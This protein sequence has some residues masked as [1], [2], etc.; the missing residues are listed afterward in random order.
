MAEFIDQNL[1]RR[2]LRKPDWYLKLTADFDRLGRL[3]E[4]ART[5]NPGQA[6][7]VKAEAYG[8]VERALTEGLIPLATQGLD[9]DR[10][11]RPVD[12][13][14]IH[15][16]KNPPGMTHERL[17]AMHLLRLYGN[18]YARLPASDAQRGQAVWSNHFRDGQPVFWGYHWFVRQ[19][20]QTERL[21]DDSQIGWQSGAW[22]VNSRSVGICIDDDLSQ[23][24]PAPAALEAIAG[25]IHKYYGNVPRHSV[26]G[27]NEVRRAT[28]CPGDLFLDGWKPELI[29]L[30]PDN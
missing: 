1:W 28:A 26:I 4:S 16:S 10:E 20:G 12:I 9:F 13:V 3:A 17:N 25:L 15:H 29:G 11:R 24:S 22:H 6:K 8:T 14:V 21:L 7:R 18:Y 30:C 27:H 23:K 2:E 5:D 19:N